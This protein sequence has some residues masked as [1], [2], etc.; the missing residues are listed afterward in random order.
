MILFKQKG[1]HLFREDA[2]REF[3]YSVDAYGAYQPASFLYLCMESFRDELNEFGIDLTRPVSFTPNEESLPWKFERKSIKNPSF[4]GL[5]TRLE[6]DKDLY[7][8]QSFLDEGKNVLALIPNE[9]NFTYN[10]YNNLEKNSIK[11]LFEKLGLEKFINKINFS[12]KDYSSKKEMWWEEIEISKGRLFITEDSFVSD[13]YYLKSYNETNEIIDRRK[14][15]ITQLITN[16]EPLLFINTFPILNTWV[17]HEL[18]SLNITVKNFGKTISNL[19]VLLNQSNQVII[20]S[21]IEFYIEKLDSR[22]EA[23]FTFFFKFSTI[24]NIYPIDSIS[25]ESTPKSR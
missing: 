10:Q 20:Q 16:R 7:E 2:Y 24:G 18:T 5:V 19:K 23:T 15:L 1:P 6:T 14:K 13:A 21:P 9:I 22:K 12:S 8:I 3:C 11:K 4:Y 25:I 17:T